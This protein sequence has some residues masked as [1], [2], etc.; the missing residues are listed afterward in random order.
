MVVSSEREARRQ[1]AREIRLQVR[2]T[3][4]GPKKQVMKTAQRAMAALIFGAEQHEE[5][6]R[7]FE[8]RQQAEAA[9]HSQGPS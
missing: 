1:K 2:S 8:G 5:A 3:P 6:K 7:A 4:A 9:R